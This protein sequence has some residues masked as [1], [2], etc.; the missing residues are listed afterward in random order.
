M[1]RKKKEIRLKEPVRIREKSLAD[2]NISLYLDIYYQGNRKKEGLKLYLVPEVSAAARI[3]NAN[4]RKLAEQIKAQRI[5][6]I[7]KDGLVDWEKVK[8]SRITLDN[9]FDRY[10]AEDAELSASSQ[11]SKRNVKARVIE[12]LN[13]IGKSSL[14]VKEVD[15]EFC[16]GF[17]AFLKTCTCR[18]KDGVKTL[19][20]TTQRLFVN[21]FGSAMAMAVREGIIDSNPFALLDKKDKPQKR[22]AEKEFLTIEEIQK[23]IDTPCRY[24]IVKKAFLF[25]CF[26]GLRYSDMKCLKWSEIRTAPDGVSQYIDH[27]QV[28]TKDRVTIPVSEETRR[29]MPERVEGIDTIFNELKITQETA[30]V[31]LTEWMKAAGITKHITFHCSR[32]TAATLLLT[33]GASIYVVSKILGHKSVKMTEVYAKIVDK[34]KIETVNL[35]N[36]MF[37][38]IAI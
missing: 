25:C 36:G 20:Q 34:S 9:W 7:Q 15:K 38:N 33:L 30:R 22:I 26:T 28:K 8:T 11:R 29:W 31:V 12:Y 6:D 23:A 32:H 18:T 2:G 37:N 17:I 16:K 14:S 27:I 21:R 4:T 10:I 35:V 19:S 24:E 1:G 13:H 3:Q 5:L